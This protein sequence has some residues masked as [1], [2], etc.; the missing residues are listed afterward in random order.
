MEKEQYEQEMDYYF[1]AISTLVLNN[2]YLYRNPNKF[3]FNPKERFIKQ[4][5]LLNS[6]LTLLSL[7]NELFILQ[8]NEETLLDLIKKEELKIDELSVWI[9]KDY[10]KHKENINKT[11]SKIEKKETN[12]IKE[13][14]RFMNNHFDEMMEV[15]HKI[16]LY[17]NNDIYVVKLR[18]VMDLIFDLF[19]ILINAFISGFDEGQEEKVKSLIN[20]I[21]YL[22]KW[23]QT[24]ISSKIN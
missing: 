5:E 19:T 8:I 1:K 2:R 3:N 7:T 4:T 9:E 12:A 11:L 22:K 17:L 20:E 10:A 24:N 15:S 13:C 18:N 6:T 21:D 14:E 23:I 16:K